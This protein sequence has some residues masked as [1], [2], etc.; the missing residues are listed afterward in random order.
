MPYLFTYQKYPNRMI[1]NTTNSLEGIN[2]SLKAKIKAHQGIRDTR[3]KKI[4]D[5]MLAK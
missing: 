1:P 2:S 3:R 5:Y 4:I